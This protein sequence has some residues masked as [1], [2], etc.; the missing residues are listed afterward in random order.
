MHLVEHHKLGTVNNKL[1]IVALGAPGPGGAICRYEITGFDTA[2]NPEARMPNGKRES[3]R[4]LVLLF[5]NGSVAEVGVNG[6]TMESLL[7]VLIDRIE[8]TPSD[9]FNAVALR[10][11]QGALEALHDRTR[12]SI[13]S[14]VERKL[15]E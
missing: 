7:A 2:E 8:E 13:V 15:A 9:E 3:I 6:I 1:N 4:R 5:Q 10:H 14:N 12:E 11:L